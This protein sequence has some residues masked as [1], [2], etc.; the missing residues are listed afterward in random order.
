MTRKRGSS[1]Y[2]AS[3]MLAPTWCG[4][5][6]VGGCFYFEIGL[7]LYPH[8][9][10]EDWSANI[11]CRLKQGCSALRSELRAAARPYS[12]AQSDV[13]CSRLLS[14]RQDVPEF[15]K[16]GIFFLRPVKRYPDGRG[17]KVQL[18]WLRKISIPYVPN[19]REYQPFLPA[20]LIGTA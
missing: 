3:A 14:M 5:C 15:W 20:N 8:A 10:M 17:L 9:A 19:I 13:T 12:P 7:Y 16:R 2:E 18:F 1:S 11:S 6:T 4:P